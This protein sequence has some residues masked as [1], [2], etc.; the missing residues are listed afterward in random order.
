MASIRTLQQWQTR[1]KIGQAIQEMAWEAETEAEFRANVS[2][3]F[4]AAELAKGYKWFGLRGASHKQQIVDAL[5]AH[6]RG[7]GWGHNK[8]AWAV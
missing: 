1:G 3:M 6:V 7:S 4:T 8:P 2:I 5:V